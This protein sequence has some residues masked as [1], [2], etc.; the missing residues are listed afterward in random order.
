Q[1]PRMLF[2]GADRSAKRPLAQTLSEAGHPARARFEAV[3]MGH[4]VRV[5]PDAGEVAG[6]ERRQL[7]TPGRVLLAHVVSEGTQDIGRV[8]DGLLELV[9]DGSRRH[10]LWR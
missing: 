4:A 7:E 2:L 10:R 1:A 3:G 6:K 8:V 9:R 5:V